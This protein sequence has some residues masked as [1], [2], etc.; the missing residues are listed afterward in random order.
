MDLS[1]DPTQ[2][3]KLPNPPKVQ[4]DVKKQTFFPLD[5]L[6]T[7]Y[8]GEWTDWLKV[9]PVASSALNFDQSLLWKP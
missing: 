3:P 5:F 6:L 9:H 7:H 2:V 8:S 4:A 1:P